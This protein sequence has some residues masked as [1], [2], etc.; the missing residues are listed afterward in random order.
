MTDRP[1]ATVTPI[2]KAPAHMRPE[3][4]IRWL[5]SHIDQIDQLA[6]VATLGQPTPIIAIT[7][8]MSPYLI[9]MSA[10]VL[11]DFALDAMEPKFPNINGGPPEDAA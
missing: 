11:N 2:A 6:V 7:D 4:L 3:M 1:K 9:A 10:S 5:M 8:G